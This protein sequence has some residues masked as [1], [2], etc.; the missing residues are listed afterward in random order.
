[1]FR[2]LE[3]EEKAREESVQEM[4][5]GARDLCQGPGRLL[6]R[7]GAGEAA[8]KNKRDFG[9][10]RSPWR[11]DVSRDLPKTGECAPLTEWAI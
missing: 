3:S 2:N 11:D 9:L 1:M 5:S 10:Q 6:G 8:E 7:V 4:D